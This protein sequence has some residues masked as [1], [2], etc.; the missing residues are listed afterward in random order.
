MEERNIFMNKKTMLRRACPRR[1]YNR[2]LNTKEEIV[3]LWSKYKVAYV[4]VLK[5]CM[6]LHIGDMC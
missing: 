2:S 1:A 3:I 6:A 5:E 4:C